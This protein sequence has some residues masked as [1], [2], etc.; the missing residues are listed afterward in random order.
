MARGAWSSSSHRWSP[1]PTSTTVDAATSTASSSTRCAT[2]CASSTTRTHTPRSR[3]APVERP[4]VVLG[5]PRTGTSLVSYLLDQDPLRRSLLTWE[6]EDSVPPVDAGHPVHRSA[7]PEEEGRTRRPRRRAQ[8]GE[9]P[10]GALGR[11]R[12]TDRMR[13]RAEPGLQ[14]LPVGG[15]HADRGVR[16]LAVAGRHGQRLRVR[17]AGTADV[18]VAGARCVVAQDAVARRPHRG[19]ADGVPRCAHRVG[20]SRPVQV[21][22]VVPAAELPVAG[23]ARRRGVRCRAER[24]APVAGPRRPADEHQE[25]ASA[26]TGSSTCTTPSS[27]A[28]P[29]A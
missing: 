2:G 14:G 15:V 3:T 23:G 7:V 8:G 17:A 10:A 9:H 27:C 16:R 28:T 18:A 5:L 22:R 1:R 4:L 13:L 11:G 29:S 20:A 26:T 12:R 6:A 19:A 25:A 24:V 21:D